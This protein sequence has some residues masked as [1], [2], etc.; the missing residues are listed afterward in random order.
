MNT[1]LLVDFS[2]RPSSVYD[3]KKVD[4]REWVACDVKVVKEV[5]LRYWE[6]KKVRGFLICYHC[7]K[8]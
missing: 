2:D 5:G 6:S 1:S 3:P 7:D 8:R 4:V